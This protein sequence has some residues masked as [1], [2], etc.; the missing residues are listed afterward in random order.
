VAALL[1]ALLLAG[2]GNCGT[3]GQERFGTTVAWE[4][5]VADAAKKAK[6]QEKL[7]FVLHVSGYFED[8]KFT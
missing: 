3:C 6:E 4:G 5:S 7:V 2:D 1:M 8:P